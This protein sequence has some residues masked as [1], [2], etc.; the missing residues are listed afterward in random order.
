MLLLAIGDEE[1][2]VLSLDD[3]GLDDGAFLQT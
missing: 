3:E 1:E 2:G